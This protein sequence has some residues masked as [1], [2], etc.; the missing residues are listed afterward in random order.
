MINQQIMDGCMRGLAE[1]DFIAKKQQ[2]IVP[3]SIVNYS[4]ILAKNADGYNMDSFNREKNQL[5]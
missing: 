4:K 5:R 3:N 2:F 1:L